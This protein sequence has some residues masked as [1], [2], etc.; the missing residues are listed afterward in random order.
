MA[1]ATAQFYF[2]FQIG[3]CRSFSDV[4]FYQQTKFYSYSSIRGWDITISGFEKQTFAILELHFLFR[5]RP[6]HRSRHVILHQSAKFYPNQTAQGRKM[7]SCRL[8]RGRISAILDVRGPIMGSWKSPCTIS[9]R[10][11]IDTIALNC[12]VFEKIRNEGSPPHLWCHS[13]TSFK[14]N[15]SK[16]KV[17]RS[18][19]G[20]TH[21]P[22]YLPN[23]KAYEL[24]T[25]TLM[26]DDDPHQPQAPWPPRSKVNVA[27]SR[28]QSEPSWAN[29]VP[30]SLE[31]GGSMCVGRT[32]R[33]HSV[34]LPRLPVPWMC[35]V[36][37]S[38]K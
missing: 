1:A 31:A 30:V 15:R 17:T 22:P 20:D 2:R 6:Y 11:S 28:D 12:L 26:E 19:D 23:D 35:S 27:R 36:H 10:S 37:K 7:T 5:F 13:H 16:I 38:Y 21:R 4:S 33:P 29:V 34:I 24:Q 3:W 8:S 32:R 9:Y 25:C 18:I 14:V